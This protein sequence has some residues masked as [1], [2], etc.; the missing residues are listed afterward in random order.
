MHTHTYAN[1]R[2]RIFAHISLFMRERSFPI[3]RIGKD[4]IFAGV[5]IKDRGVRLHIIELKDLF[6]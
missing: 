6:L 4:L 1:A 2:A 3:R 5:S